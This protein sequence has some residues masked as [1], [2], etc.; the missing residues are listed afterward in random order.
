VSADGSV[1]YAGDYQKSFTMQSIIKPINF[2]CALIDRWEEAAH[3]LVGVE[4]TVKPFDAFN[5]SNHALKR[6]HM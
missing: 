6:A 3:I 2:L 1:N 4:S 5:Y